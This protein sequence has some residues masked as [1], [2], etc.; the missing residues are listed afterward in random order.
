MHHLKDLIVCLGFL[1]FI[2][3]SSIVSIT[4]QFYICFVFL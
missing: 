3:S 1:F 2:L 4:F